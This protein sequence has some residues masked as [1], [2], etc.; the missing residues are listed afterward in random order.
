MFISENQSQGSIKYRTRRCHQKSRTG[1]Q[2]CK[3]RRIKCD[4]EKPSCTRCVLSLQSCVYSPKALFIVDPGARDEL[5]LQT[6]QRSVSLSPIAPSFL[7]NSL[8]SEASAYSTPALTKETCHNEAEDSLPPSDTILYHHYLQHTSHITTHHQNDK[9][10]LEIYIPTLALQSKVVF[11]SILALSAA[12]LCRD[13]IAERTSSDIAA[14][15]Q[16]LMAGYRHYNRA[17]EQT[18]DLIS[19]PNTPKPEHLLA[20]TP[21]LIGFATASQQINHWIESR[22]PTRDPSQPLIAS[23]RD[24]IILIKGLRATLQV[25]RRDDVSS[26]HKMAYEPELPNENEPAL[27][28]SKPPAT[29]PPPSHTHVMYPMIAATSEGAFSRLQERLDS[30][31]LSYGDDASLVACAEAFQRLSTVRNLTFSSHAPPTPLSLD[32]ASKLPRLPPWLRSYI[33]RPVI[34]LPNEPLVRPFLTFLIRSSQEYLDLLLPLLDESLEGPIEPMPDG[35]P[36]LTEA[37]ALALDIWAHWCVLMFL[38]EEEAWWIGNLPFILLTGMLNRYGDD[39]VARLW[40][41]N[42]QGQDRWW[43]ASM[44]ACLGEVKRCQ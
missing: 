36:G 5:P 27:L 7:D 3:R 4:E 17:S 34:L 11:H 12:C 21:F 22:K 33:G 13:M 26:S 44:L 2:E 10:V 32:N 42:G 43:P 39:F 16:V 38:V 18:R 1:C 35:L 19:Q 37:Q 24:T 29:T 30:T 31:S 40:P 6:A 41:G 20:S 14:V 9:T 15:N 23:L 8:L 25:L 28:E